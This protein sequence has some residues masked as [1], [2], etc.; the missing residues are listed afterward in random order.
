M[1]QTVE[2]MIDCS[3]Q[4]HLL[5]EVHACGVRRALVIVLDEPPRVSDTALASEAALALD[6][7]RPEEDAAWRHLNE[8]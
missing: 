7:G 2:A 1:I 6:W 5:G 8:A 3:G 4:I